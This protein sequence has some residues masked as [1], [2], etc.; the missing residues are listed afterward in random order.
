M[1]RKIFAFF[2]FFLLFTTR[3]NAQSGVYQDYR[4]DYRQIP[5]Y[6]KTVQWIVEPKGS[7]QT[8]YFRQNLGFSEDETAFIVPFKGENVS[9]ST[10]DKDV[11]KDVADQTGLNS[12]FAEQT[13]PFALSPK[14]YTKSNK[15][16]LL[17]AIKNKNYDIDNVYLKQIDNWFNDRLSLLFFSLGPVK[18]SRITWTKPLKI[19]LNNPQ[20][21]I[22][23]VWLRPGYSK[24]TTS[25]NKVIYAQDFEGGTGGW[26]DEFQGDG[27]NSLVTRD[28]SEHFDGDFSLK[29][30]NKPGS[31]NALTTQTLGPLTTGE[32][33]TFSAYVKN[34]TITSDVAR[35]RVMGD[36]LVQ[37]NDGLPM[38]NGLGHEWQRMSVAFQARSAY[39]FFT[40]M[41]GGEGGQYLY[42]DDIQLEKGTTASPF[43][44]NKVG[45]N[46][47]DLA[48]EDLV[49]TSVDTEIMVFGD[50]AYT[51]NNPQWRKYFYQLGGSKPSFVSSSTLSLIRASINP[52]NAGSFVQFEKSNEQL[53]P[54]LPN[55]HKQ[56][57][58]N[59]LPLI[60][61][62]LILAALVLMKLLVVL[63]AKVE[64]EK[65][66]SLIF[67]IV[68]FAGWLIN[69]VSVSLLSVYYYGLWITG[70]NILDS[71]ST[72]FLTFFVITLATYLLVFL[73]ILRKNILQ[74]RKIAEIQ[75][76]AVIILLLV[77]FSLIVSDIYGVFNSNM[78]VLAN[79]G[80]NPLKLMF[81]SKV[82]SFVILL[83]EFFVLL[84]LFSK[85]KK[86][87][88]N[89]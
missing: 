21:E 35:L 81:L 73:F 27:A 60:A 19:S 45:T 28:N 20:V 85:S 37:L 46:N 61:V 42:W 5:A 16:E 13:V 77:S 89:V 48:K 26:Q 83:L 84:K 69:I 57:N 8:I 66:L 54:L 36:G 40:L 82:P 18:D 39:H 74:V 38:Y 12:Y 23:V 43:Q 71:A 34:G 49:T 32:H 24:I 22:P 14:I 11:W 33:Y 70:G 53:Q 62:T 88:P 55:E 29:V 9:V 7:S 47:S 52:T 31:I 30:Q 2:L 80:N 6:S 41:A 56:S 59:S 44:K 3:V 78:Y 76:G 67:P 68:Y 79:A 15:D 1:L 51:T 65:E 25:K 75:I 50:S 87:H 17:S 58:K 63:F 72:F 10:E 64:G 4:G 86:Q